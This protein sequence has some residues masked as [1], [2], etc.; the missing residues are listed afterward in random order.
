[1]AL[2]NIFQNKLTTLSLLFFLVAAGGGGWV[3]HKYG[4][5]LN[6]LNAKDPEQFSL[7][8][9]EVRGL[10]FFE[11][12]KLVIELDRLTP[13]QVYWNR[14]RRLKRKMQ[15]DKDFKRDVMQK[16]REIWEEVRA[17]KKKYYDRQ[18]REAEWKF[19][20]NDQTDFARLCQT[21]YP[22]PEICSIGG[23]G[24]IAKL[25]SPTQFI[26]WSEMGPWQKG[27]VIRETCGRILSDEKKFPASFCGRAIPLGHDDRFVIRALENLKMEM[28]Y[29]KFSRLLSEAG[30]PGKNMFSP[31]GKL[32]KMTGSL[33]G[34]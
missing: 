4:P 9:K 22:F 6:E 7:I 28:D 10:H 26:Y 2:L 8:L 15:S 12:R 25:N 32:V 24:T 1:M 29:F 34:A 21:Q 16:R 14:Y 23:E 19:A 18:I 5:L 20:G 11:A 13:N 17:E 3:W 31:S 33:G 27:L 30:I